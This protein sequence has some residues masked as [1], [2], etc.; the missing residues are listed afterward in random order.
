[1]PLNHQVFLE[2][3]GFPTKI[4]LSIGKSLSYQNNSMYTGGWYVV[5]TL[6]TTLNS[7]LTDFNCTLL[8]TISSY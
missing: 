2:K 7:Y 5:T 4:A 6:A 1:M 3:N 8:C